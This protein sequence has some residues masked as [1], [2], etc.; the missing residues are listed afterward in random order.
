ME[1]AVSSSVVES[2]EAVKTVA[3]ED[4]SVVFSDRSEDVVSS[5][6][7]DVVSSGRPDV[8]SSD[9][10]EDVVSSISLVVIPLSACLIAT[11]LSGSDNFQ[12]FSLWA[13]LYK[14]TWLHVH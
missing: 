11:Y 9:R 13:V 8:V 5:G 6:R 7:P 12:L 3:E 2:S 1:D 10:S 14:F 4:S